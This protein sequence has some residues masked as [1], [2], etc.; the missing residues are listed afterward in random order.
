MCWFKEKTAVAEDGRG[1][2]PAIY[3][4]MSKIE[5]RGR[6]VNQPHV[7]NGGI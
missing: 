1:C 7:F 2:F 3:Y 4:G 5:H 6:A